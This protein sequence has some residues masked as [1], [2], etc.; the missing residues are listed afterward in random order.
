M[1]HVGNDQAERDILARQEN[2]RR[3]AA[4]GQRRQSMVSHGRKLQA[5]AMRRDGFTVPEIAASIRVDQ[6]TVQRYLEGV[7]SAT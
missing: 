1:R 6:R 4:E 7:T 2:L 5:E 3:Y